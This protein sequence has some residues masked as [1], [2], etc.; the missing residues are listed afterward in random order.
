MEKS[1]STWRS[2]F[3]IARLCSTWRSRLPHGDFVFHM[4]RMSSAW[5]L[6]GLHLGINWEIFHPNLELCTTHSNALERPTPHTEDGRSRHSRPA[7]VRRHQV[8]VM[9]LNLATRWEKL[10]SQRDNILE[11]PM[12][13]PFYPAMIDA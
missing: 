8:P 2:C 9:A 4:E 13:S 7:L 6:H 10:S 11:L 1:V 3:H 5:K 12:C